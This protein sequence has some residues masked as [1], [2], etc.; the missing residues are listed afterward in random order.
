MVAEWGP[1]YQGRRT[2]SSLTVYLTLNTVVLKV[3]LLQGN[4]DLSFRIKGHK[5]LSV[6]CIYYDNNLIFDVL[7]AS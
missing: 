6:I 3:H 2:F 1:V 4:V 7:F 5:G